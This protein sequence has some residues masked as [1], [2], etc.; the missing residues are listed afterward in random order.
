V[1]VSLAL[2]GTVSAEHGIGLTKREALIRML[3]SAELDIMRAVKAA[4]DPQ[5]VLNPEKLFQTPAR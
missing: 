1:D 2:G 4:L 3:S 5:V